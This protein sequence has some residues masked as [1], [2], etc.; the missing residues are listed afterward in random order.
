M[1]TQLL[2]LK[3]VCHKLSVSSSFI[4]KHM[5]LGRFPR[6]VELGPRCVRWRESDLDKWIEEKFSE[7][8]LS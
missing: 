8:S 4:Y 7:A 3:E 2:K 6:P 1:S 5:Q